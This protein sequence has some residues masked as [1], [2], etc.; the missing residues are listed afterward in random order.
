MVD[1]FNDY[2]IAVVGEE[3]MGIPGIGFV[4]A[5]ACGCAFIGQTV[6]YYEDYGMKEGIHYI[7][8]D[9]TKE[10]LARTIEYWQRPENQEKLEAIADA[11]YKFVKN[12]FKGEVITSNLIS[13]INK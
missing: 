3:I 5:M 7:G 4:E 8:Y 10:G 13:Q 9:G 6:G 11:G 12:N 2:K 1:K